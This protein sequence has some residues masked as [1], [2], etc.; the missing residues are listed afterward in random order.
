MFDLLEQIANVWREKKMYIYNQNTQTINISAA[1]NV[2]K[3]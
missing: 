1:S 2:H 3:G